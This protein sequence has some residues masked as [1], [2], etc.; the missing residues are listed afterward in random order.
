MLDLQ[1][2]HL[3][4]IGLFQLGRW[5][6]RKKESLERK[7]AQALQDLENCG[8]TKLGIRTQWQL[9]QHDATK[10]APSKFQFSFSVAAAYYL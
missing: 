3:N 10:K 7:R 6:R 2:A 4:H 1:M 5:W 9:Q 8:T